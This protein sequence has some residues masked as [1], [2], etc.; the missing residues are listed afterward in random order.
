MM[1]GTGGEAASLPAFFVPKY[2][3]AAE[4]LTPI[5]LALTHARMRVPWGTVEQMFGIDR[6]GRA[7]IC[8]MATGQ[9]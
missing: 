5:G 7:V 8:S 3:Y 6:V 2:H 9:Y 4:R 1:P